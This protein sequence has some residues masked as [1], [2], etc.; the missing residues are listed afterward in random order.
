VGAHYD[1]RPFTGAAPGANDNG[2]GLA[3]MLSVARAFVE[4]GIKPKKTLYF[5]GFAGEEAGLYGSEHFAQRLKEGSELCGEEPHRAPP[6]GAGSRFLR[7]LDTLLDPRARSFW[8]SAEPSHTAIVLDEIG[9]VTPKFSKQTVTLESYDWASGITDQLKC[10]SERQNGDGLE[11]VYN[12]APFSSDHM[13]FLERGMKAVLVINGDDANYPNYHTSS[14]TVDKVTPEYAA[15]I[16][17]MVAA[18]AVRLAG[19]RA[20]NPS[21]STE[22]MPPSMLYPAAAPE[23]APPFSQAALAH[24]SLLLLLLLTWSM[25]S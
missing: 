24:P 21:E 2:S 1:S 8:Q 19:S 17:K 4:S 13:S 16:T 7:K 5:V 15:K 25:A 20:L 10:S 14:D 3:A 22:S 12:K 9:W 18:A 23:T 6:P 11:V